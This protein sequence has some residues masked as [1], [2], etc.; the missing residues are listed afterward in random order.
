MDRMPPQAKIYT[1]YLIGYG[2]SD[3]DDILQKV[4]HEATQEMR[5]GPS[6]PACRSRFQTTLSCVGKEPGW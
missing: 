3:F 1:V 6:E 2:G 4:R 5:V